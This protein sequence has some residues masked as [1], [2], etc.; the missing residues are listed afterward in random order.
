MKNL[1]F[2]IAGLIPA[3]AQA[4]SLPASPTDAAH[5]GSKIYS[6]GFEQKDITCDSR[7]VKVFLPTGGSAN[8][9]FPVVVYGH[10][11]ALDV[12]NYEGTFEHLAQKGVATVFPN[13]DDGFFDQ[14]WTRMASD[15]GHLTDCAMSNFPALNAGQVIFSGHS[16][17]AYIAGMAAGRPGKTHPRAVILFE[18][19]GID[20]SFT[21]NMDPQTSLTVVFGDA[22]TTVD[23]SISDRIYSLA[24]SAKKQFILLKSYTQTSPELSADH[25]W[26]QTKG[27]VFGGGEE[28]SFHYYGEWKWLV[29]AGMDLKSSAPF[30]NPYLYGNEALDKGI[31]GFVDEVQRN[32]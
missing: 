27:T 28:S 12:T 10:G 21:K 8:E 25:F 9:T 13:Y 7:E 14:N 19:A 30:T 4:V 20:E 31:P 22:D 16:K 23:K 29:A 5:P 17:G 24:P 15:F 32:F 11:Q 26:P 2:I 18:A 6:Y 3:M 1:I